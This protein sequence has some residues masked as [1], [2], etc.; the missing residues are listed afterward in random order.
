ML[1]IYI[2]T[3]LLQFL[4]HQLAP[5]LS[6]TRKVTSSSTTASCICVPAVAVAEGLLG[7][8]GPPPPNPPIPPGC[9]FWKVLPDPPAPPA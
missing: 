6:S 7:A 4:N 3:L 9:H 8:P 1:S 2:C 5:L